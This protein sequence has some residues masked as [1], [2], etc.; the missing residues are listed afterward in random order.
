MQYTITTDRGRTLIYAKDPEEAAKQFAERLP[1][2][3]TA[4]MEWIA[5]VAGERIY[6]F[7]AGRTTFSVR[8]TLEGD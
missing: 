7:K 3:P 2:K 8:R 6:D 5:D 1:K 4:R